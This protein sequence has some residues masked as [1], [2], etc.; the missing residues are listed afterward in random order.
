[1]KFYSELTDELYTSVEELENAEC[2]Y[3]Q[4]LT[5]Q[6]QKEKSKNDRLVEVEEAVKHARKLFEDFIEDYGVAGWYS[7]FL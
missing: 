3:K 6:E 5:E 4:D 2:K 7:L 1:M